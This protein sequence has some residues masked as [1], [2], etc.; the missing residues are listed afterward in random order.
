MT[1]EPVTAII[2]RALRKEEAFQ[3]LIF[4]TKFQK[5]FSV[6]KKKDLH[7][8]VKF[9]LLFTGVVFSCIYSKGTVNSIVPKYKIGKP[10][11]Y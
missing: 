3:N 6:K 9:F 2:A 8:L 4:L 10:E 11:K 7:I 5:Y 1:F